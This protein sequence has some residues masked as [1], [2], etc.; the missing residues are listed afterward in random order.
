MTTALLSVWDK[1]GIVAFARVLHESGVNILSSGGTGKAL[2]DAG[3]PFTEVSAYTGSP[4]MMDGRVKTLHPKIHG[5]LLGRRGIDDSVMAEHG[6]P[7]IDLLVVNLYPFEA[8]SAQNLP[9]EDLI[10]FIDIGGPA[11]I[12]A[13]A[14]NYKDV[15]VICDP[16]D[17]P[18]ITEALGKGGLT[19]QMRL[20][21]AKKAFARTAAYDAAISN[22]LNSLD[23]TFPSVLTVQFQSG[24]ML[25]YGENPHQQAAVYGTVGIAGIEPLQGKQMSY[26]NYLDLNS[27]VGLLREFDDPACVIVKHNNP[28]GVATGKKPID[29]YIRARDVDPVSAYGSVV[30]LNR[31]VGSDVAEAICST[32]VEVIIAPAFSAEALEMMKAKENMRVLILPH[33]SLADEIRS[34]DGGILCMRTPPYLEHWEVVSE[35]EPTATELEAMRLAWRVC[36]HTKSNTI[37]FANKEEALGIGAGQMSRVDAAK[38]AIEK[39]GKSLKGSVVASDAFL[40][41]PDTLE[42]AA[43]AGA[44]ALIQPGG[45]IRDAEVIEAANKRNMA[46][47]FTGVRYFRH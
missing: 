8:M 46:M 37:I 28:C 29:A 1:T 6:I 30:A 17:Y 36:K 19:T 10:E 32:F 23:S 27:A 43:D 44:T 3:I 4:E 45:S 5:G 2:K 42:V 15:A 9:I 20:S 25:R 34:I 16:A 24:R 47:V 7:P 41:F 38:I 13:A 22:H 40:P 31:E 18:A 11:M 33:P 12:R 39:A 35:R 26:N 14:K 21:L